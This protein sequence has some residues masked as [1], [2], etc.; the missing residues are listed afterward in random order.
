MKIIVFCPEWEVLYEKCVSI[1]DRLRSLSIDCELRTTITISDL[2]LL[3][4]YESIVKVPQ[5]II[6]EDSK[7]VKRLSR[8]VIESNNVDNLVKLI[9]EYSSN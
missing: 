3:E 2:K 4:T 5:I 1:I 6:L 9:V 7:I 8:D